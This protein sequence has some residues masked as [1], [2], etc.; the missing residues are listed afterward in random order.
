ILSLLVIIF[1]ASLAYRM[2]HPY[3]QQKV[4]R[5]TYSGSR[6]RVIVK[7][8][9]AKGDDEVLKCP[10]VLMG[11]FA[12]SQHHHGEVIH[13]PFFRPEAKA[14][15]EIKP[16]VEVA[17]PPEET[18]KPPGEDPRVRAQRELSSFRVFGS[19][20]GNGTNMLFLERG[21]DIFIVRPG[22]KI[23]GKYLVRSI[24]GNSLEVW[25]EEIQEDI[26]IDL[27]DF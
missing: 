27:S 17:K 20:Q 13:D 9:T 24:N 6:K 22:D 21:K 19:C 15:R 14:P 26:H 12:K 7:K 8:N 2:T 23:D 4:P 11:L 5:L 18:S 3:R 1:V 25:A 16:P 10:E